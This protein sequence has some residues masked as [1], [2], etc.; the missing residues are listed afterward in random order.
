M[1]FLPASTND[2]Y[3]GSPAAAYFL[4]LTAVLTIIPGLIHTLLPDGGAGVIAGLDLSHNPSLIIGMFAWVGAVQVPHGIA[5]LLVALRY[6][7]FVPL[8]LA[9]TLLERVLVVLAGWVL[10]PPASGHHPP[11]HYASVIVLPLLALFLA[12][13]LRR[14]R[15]A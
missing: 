5:V 15:A 1:P 12:L 4:G 2:Q 8:F 7:T 14:Q 11:E 3:E 10:K 6:R 9:L 13:S